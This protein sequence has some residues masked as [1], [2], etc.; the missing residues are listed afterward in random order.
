MFKYIRS[1]IAPIL[2]KTVLAHFVLIFLNT[3]LRMRCKRLFHSLSGIHKRE[4]VNLII[5]KRSRESFK[6]LAL[7]LGLKVQ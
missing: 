4:A 6:S 7:N 1:F 3:Y 5:E 2:V